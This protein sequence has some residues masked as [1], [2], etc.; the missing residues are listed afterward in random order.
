MLQCQLA[1]KIETGVSKLA[2]LRVVLSSF[3]ERIGKFE[4]LFKG[5]QRPGFLDTLMK[6]QVSLHYYGESVQYY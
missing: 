4:A 2:E 5:E 3:L 6:L 1:G